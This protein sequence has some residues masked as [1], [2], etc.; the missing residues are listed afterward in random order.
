MALLQISFFSCRLILIKRALS[1]YFDR[2]IVKNKSKYESLKKEKQQLLD[3]VMENETFKVA[4]EI[5]EKYAPNHL[6]PKYLADQQRA[7]PMSLTPIP[8]TGQG[9]RRRTTSSFSSST[10]PTPIPY[11]GMGN[12]TPRP[13]RPYGLTNSGQYM[14]QPT[15]SFNRPAIMPG[16]STPGGPG[17]KFVALEII[18]YASKC[19]INGLRIAVG[20]MPRG[21][22]PPRFMLPPPPTNPQYRTRKTGWLDKMVDYVVGDGPA[23]RFALICRYC[24]THNGLATPDDF[25]YIGKVEN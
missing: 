23:N 9:L 7:S 11:P 4:K 12:M 5:L 25:P 22:P 1:W 8:R 19:T 18:N 17:M 15:N 3:D 14:R 21:P 13:I 10:T 6:L 20:M 16:P 24:A 2:K